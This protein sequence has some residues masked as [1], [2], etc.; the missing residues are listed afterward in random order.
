MMPDFESIENAFYSKLIATDDIPPPELIQR[1]NS[2]FVP[3]ATMPRQA[4]LRCWL[5]DIDTTQIAT[6][7][8]ESR[9]FFRIDVQ[10][11]KS[12]GNL[13]PRRIAKRIL[14]AFEPSTSLELNGQVVVIDR[15]EVVR[16]G[17]D[18]D[19]TR[20][21]IA[22]LWWTVELRILWRAGATLATQA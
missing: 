5:V 1:E 17:V 13:E 12:G 9:G 2:N 3:P 4:W 18:L 11:P 8:V 6:G 21:D 20:G 19:R 15:A 16:S 14:E 7:W 22:D 10:Y